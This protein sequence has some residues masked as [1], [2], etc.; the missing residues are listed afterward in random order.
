VVLISIDTLRADRLPMYGYREV[1]TPTFDQLRAD[2]V[3]FRNAYAHT[4][5]TLPS[6]ATLLTGLLP[7]QT[8]VRD[9]VGYLL[10]RQAMQSGTV[11]HLAKLLRDRGY[12]TG[13]AVSAYVLDGRTGLGEGFEEYRDEVEFRTSAGLGGLQRAGGE[14]LT[15]ILPWLRGAAAKPFFLFFHLYEPHTPYEPPAKFAHFQSPYDGEIAAADE[16]VGA[17]LAELK[18]LGAYERSLIVLVSDHGEG[19]GDHG[20]DEHGVF[21]YRE[22]IHVPLIIKLPGQARAGQSLDAPAGLFDVAPTVLRALEMPVPAPMRGR[23]LFEPAPAGRRIYSETFYPRLHFGWNDLASL[24]DE[25]YQLIDGPDPELYDTVADPRQKTNLR[26]AERRTFGEMRRELSAHSRVLQAPAA[27]DE[28]TRQAMAALGYLGSASAVDSSPLPDPKS[29]IGTMTDF[30]DGM[31]RMAAKDNRA[32][33]EAFRRTVKANPRMT[34]A[35]EFLARVLERQGELD[36]AIDAY[37]RALKASGGSTHVA[38]ALASIYLGLNRLPEAETHARMAMAASPGMARGLL[39]QIAKE[40]GDLEAA[41]REARASIAEKGDRVGPLVALAD[42]LNARGRYE[43]ALARVRE[44]EAVYAQR[45]TPDPDLLRGLALTE[46]KIHADRGDAVAAEAAFRKEIERFPQELRAYS[47]LAILYALIGRAPQAGLTLKRMVET[48][49]SASAYAEA[50]K[51]YR[52]LR[53]EAGASRLLRFALARFPESAELRRLL[54]ESGL[55]K[56]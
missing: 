53:D 56:T 15:A 4:P 30:R 46:G 33:A 1:A 14:T 42:V 47:G 23:A 19:L 32:A 27:I 38:A 40:R 7:E 17:L 55:K 6:H 2:A 8:G 3:L 18:A 10:D 5:L 28:E 25:R 21:L 35:W 44:A 34:D 13:G 43:E 51:T 12:A 29:K 45:K 49:P 9:N 26:D 37:Q 20:E 11:P 48:N 22:A 54:T 41:E 52:V 36:G 50:V 39:A 24:A 16:I 31:R